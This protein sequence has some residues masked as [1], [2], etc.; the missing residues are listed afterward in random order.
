[1]RSLVKGSPLGTKVYIEYIRASGPDGTVRA[2]SPMNFV[3]N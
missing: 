2:L 3:L 1:M